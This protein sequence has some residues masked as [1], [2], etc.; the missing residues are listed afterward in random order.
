MRY[1]QLELI[2]CEDVLPNVPHASYRMG[3][4]RMRSYLIP[5]KTCCSETAFRL[6]TVKMIWNCRPIESVNSFKPLL[7]M[8]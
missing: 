4:V 2:L 6:S 8:P 7:E 5:R 1:P 3:V